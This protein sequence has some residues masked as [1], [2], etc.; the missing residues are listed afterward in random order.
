MSQMSEDWLVPVI[1]NDLSGHLSKVLMFFFQF[2]WKVKMR[3]PTL[4]TVVFMAFD[5]RVRVEIEIQ[6]WH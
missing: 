5:V 1:Y 4:L 2:A 6:N 3:L